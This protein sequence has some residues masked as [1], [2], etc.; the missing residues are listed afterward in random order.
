MKGGFFQ[1]T[2]DFHKQVVAININF[3]NFVN[4]RFYAYDFHKPCKCTM[5]N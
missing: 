3:Y 4:N 2:T 5:F 1:K